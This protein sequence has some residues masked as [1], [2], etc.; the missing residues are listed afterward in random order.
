MAA[1]P[2]VARVRVRG[3]AAAGTTV[4]LEGRVDDVAAPAVVGVALEDGRVDALVVAARGVGGRVPGPG[5]QPL[6]Q[7]SV[8]GQHWPTQ[9]TVPSGQPQCKLRHTMSGRQTCP[10]DP[11]LTGSMSVS[12]QMPA[13]Q[14]TKGRPL[15]G[16]ESNA[17]GAT[18]VRPSY[19]VSNTVSATA[20]DAGSGAAAAAHSLAPWAACGH[21]AAFRHCRRRRRSRSAGQSR[22]RCRRR[23]S[24]CRS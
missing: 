13:Q 24:A 22:R 12:A 15:G 21:P 4:W 6:G 10:Q 1:R 19:F 18:V 23:R 3:G 17:A 14:W 16:E 2:A 7:Q 9:S 8:S 20:L 5:S 11:Q